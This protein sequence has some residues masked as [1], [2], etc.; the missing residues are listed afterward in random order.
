MIYDPCYFPAVNI[1]SIW[2]L[3]G[4]KRRPVSD[5]RASLLRSAAA[6]KRPVNERDV[7]LHLWKNYVAFA[8]R[9]VPPSGSAVLRCASPDISLRFLIRSHPPVNSIHIHLFEMWE[10]HSIRI[11]LKSAL[12]Q[13]KPKRIQF[14]FHW[15]VTRM[16]GSD[17]NTGGGGWMFGCFIHLIQLVDWLWAVV[18]RTVCWARRATPGCRRWALCHRRRSTN[19]SSLYCAVRWPTCATRSSALSEWSTTPPSGNAPPT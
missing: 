12:N 1:K 15:R 5:N 4:M 11:R 19:W 9:V 6:V 3:G 18:R 2:M 17:V 10:S 13:L 16:D 8:C 14:E 7:Y